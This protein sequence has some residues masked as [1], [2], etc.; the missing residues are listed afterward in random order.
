M[1]DKIGRIINMVSFGQRDFMDRIKLPKRVMFPALAVVLTALLLSPI[2]VPYAIKVPGKIMPAQEWVLERGVDGRLIS[3]LHDFRKG[4]T[5]SYSV[6]Q[7]ERGDAM[8]FTLSPSIAQNA[9]ISTDSIVGWIYSNDLEHRLA[10]LRGELSV[11]DASLISFRNG[12]KRSIVH[13]AEQRLIY[14]KKQAEEHRKV[15]ERQSVLYAYKIITKEEY[16]QV[17][18]E[19]ELLSVNIDIAEAQLES[20]RTGEKPEELEIVQSRINA[21]K[22]EIAALQKKLN[23]FTITSPISGRITS[24]FSGDTLL[25][26]ADTT[27]YVIFMPV[28]WHEKQYF[29]LHQEMEFSFIK[30]PGE[31]HGEMINVEKTIQYIQG[32]PVVLATALVINDSQPV[33]TGIIAQCVIDCQ[34]VTLFEYMK[35]KIKALIV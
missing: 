31:G 34:P 29:S 32:E 21:L 26:V 4:T 8:S 24:G 14:A 25:I 27:N 13:E 18:G 23:M 17:V 9:V 6:T 28:K 19:A 30:I 11:S 5:R 33:F 15:L 12:E 35:R 1:T 22:G 20:A 10:E 16:E 7:F 3:C 2:K